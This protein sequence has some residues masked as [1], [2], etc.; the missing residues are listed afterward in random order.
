MI[1]IFKLFFLSCLPIF[2]FGQK[3]VAIKIVS[4][5]SPTDNLVNTQFTLQL[6]EEIQVLLKSRYTFDFDIV[7]TAH[8]LGKIISEFE[9]SFADDKTDIIIASGPMTSNVLAQWSSY[10]KPAIATTIINQELQSIKITPEGSSGVENFTFVQTPFDIQ[11]DLTTLYRIFPY[12]KMG[13]VGVGETIRYSPAFDKLFEDLLKQIG[14]QYTFIP[15]QNTVDASL[16]SIPDDVDALYLLPLFDGLNQENEKTFIKGIVDK[17]LPAAALLGEQMVEPG[18]LMGYE[19]NNNFRRIPRRVALNVSKIL[20]GED[21]SNLPVNIPTYNENLLINMA[22]AAKIEKYPDWDMMGDATLLH[23]DEVE[24]NNKWS[25]ESAVAYALTN[26]LDIKIAEKDPQIAEKDIGLAKAEYLPQVDLSSTLLLVDEITAFSYQGVRGRWSWT[27]SVSATQILFSEP[28]FANIAIQE[29]L[30]ESQ[31][32][33]LY[34]TQL[35]AILDVTTA[36]LNVLQ[37][38]RGVQIQNENVNVTKRNL[39]IASAKLAVGYSGATDINRW[40]SELALANIDLNNAQASLRQARYSFNQLLNRPIDEDFI[41]DEITF[42]GDPLLFVNDGR[43]DPLITNP[44]DLEIFADFLVEDAF[45]RLPEIT[46]LDKNIAATDRQLLSLKRRFTLPTLAVSASTDYLIDTWQIPEQVTP[47]DV[48]NTWSAGLSLQYPLFQ[49]GKRKLNVDQTKLSLLQLADQKKNLYNQLELLI[50]ANLETVGA[51]YSA[52]ILSREAAAA[53]KKNFEIIQDS[54]S[55]GQVN[56]TT[57]I[58]AQITAIQTELTAVNAGY[59]FM[60][61]FLTLERSTGGYYFLDT[62]EGKDSFF[63]RLTEF[64]IQNK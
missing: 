25:L 36:Y 44:G 33:V 8:D 48:T 55:Q 45:T 53:A 60:V 57:L 63:Q 7:Y 58:D 17:K 42:S 49:G 19:A 20:E 46:Q 56:V 9:Q 1:R 3:P 37:A 23:V 11:R 2:L 41:L 12:K 18:V 15:I 34:Q 4:D 22:T 64:L 47:L 21:A 10:A 39:D 43:M 51:S 28:A 13:I 52:T 62:P 35:D 40:E 61:D 24:T 31:E 30:K 26:N 29:L 6:Q 5:N 14:A 54:Y 38:K 16:S 27:A 59:Q 32:A 50:R